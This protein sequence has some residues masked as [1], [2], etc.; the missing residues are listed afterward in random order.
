MTRVE[1]LRERKLQRGCIVDAYTVPA[2]R[3]RLRDVIGRTEPDAASR[4][5]S[6]MLL[7]IDQSESAVIEHDYDQRQ[8]QV[9]QCC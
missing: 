6:V 5:S 8:C 4:K 2:E 3:L 7:L 9:A 1:C